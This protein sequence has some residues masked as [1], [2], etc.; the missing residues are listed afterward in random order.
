MRILKKT[1]AVMALS[2]IA[3]S[4]FAQ[5]VPF[6]TTSITDTNQPSFYFTKDG[7][8]D[9][10]IVVEKDVK[11]GYHYAADQLAKYNAVKF[12]DSRLITFAVLFYY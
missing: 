10:V 11:K 9:A 3:V 5:Q 2:V 1:L 8:A 7:V 12:F 4:A 6:R